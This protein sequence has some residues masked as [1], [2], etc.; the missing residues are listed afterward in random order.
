[1]AR[2]LVRVVP[3]EGGAVETALG[4]VL[5]GMPTRNG[6]SSVISKSRWALIIGSAEV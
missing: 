6:L 3:G 1:M 2:W 4:A 5:W